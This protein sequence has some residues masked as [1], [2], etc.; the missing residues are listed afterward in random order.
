MASFPCILL[1]KLLCANFLPREVKWTLHP[2]PKWG[3]VKATLQKRDIAVVVGKQAVSLLSP[4]SMSQLP[5]P[6][7]KYKRGPCNGVLPGDKKNGMLRYQL[8]FLQTA[9]ACT[10]SPGEHRIVLSFLFTICLCASSD[11]GS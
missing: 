4:V 2:P 11:L 10:R 1:L 8:S 7:Y 3:N 5:V 9:Q 6:Q